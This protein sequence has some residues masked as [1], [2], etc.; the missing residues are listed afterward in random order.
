[1]RRPPGGEVL[2]PKA[3]RL[4][5][6]RPPPES[7]SEV[8]EGIVRELRPIAGQVPPPVLGAAVRRHMEEM[9]RLIW[10]LRE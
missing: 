6:R 9:S 10:W 8:A 7:V 1:V 4:V 3:R 2:I 5:R